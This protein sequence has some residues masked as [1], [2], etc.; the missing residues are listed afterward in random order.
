MASN[1]TGQK[2]Y[3]SRSSL[4]QHY[5]LE[6]IATGI[7]MRTMAETNTRGM[8]MRGRGKERGNGRR[9]E[10]PRHKARVSFKK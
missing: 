3:I 1:E 5:F 8:E 9:A 2:Y 4:P 10:E 7:I 6:L